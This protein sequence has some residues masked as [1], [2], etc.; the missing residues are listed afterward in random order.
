[1]VTLHVEGVAA[2]CGGGPV[3]SG[4]EGEYTATVRSRP[5][6]E[7]SVLLALEPVEA[8]CGDF[9]AQDVARIVE[10]VAA[11]GSGG[12][13]CELERAWPPTRHG[14]AA[15]APFASGGGGDGAPFAL[16]RRDR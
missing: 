10:I 14:E 7:R 11:A 9:S 3:R 12:P 13:R 5:C 15:D 1:M 6:L 2:G 8:P 4:G 16:P